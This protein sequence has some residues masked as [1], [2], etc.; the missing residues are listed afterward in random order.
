[1]L[2]IPRSS[3]AIENRQRKELKRDVELRQLQESIRDNG[4]LHPIVVAELGENQY[5]LVAGGRRLTA[6][7]WLFESQTS[8]YCDKELITPG[9]VPVILFHQAADILAREKAELAENDDRVDLT[10]QDKAQA[11]IRIHELEQTINPKQTLVDTAAELGRVL[12]RPAA[13]MAVAMTRAK[14]IVQHIADPAIRYARNENE[15]YGLAIRKEEAQ[16]RALIVKQSSSLPTNIK[17]IEGDSFVELPKLESS[18]IDLIIADPPYGISVGAEGFKNRTVHHHNYEDTPVAAR[19]LIQVILTEGFRITRPRSNLF[20]FCDIDLFPW[21]LS[22]AEAAGWTPFRTPI[23]WA[24]SDSEGLAPWGSQ[25]FRRTYELIFFA[26]KG[27]RGLI[28]SPVDILR[29]SRVG[30]AERDYAAAK[31]IS[32]LKELISCSTLPG[33]TIL[34]PCCGSGSALLAAKELKRVAIGI[35]K[36]NNAFN[37][38]M[39]KLADVI[40]GGPNYAQTTQSPEPE[41]GDL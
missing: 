29:H 20:I 3:I 34:D 1:M 11:L 14:K 39:A 9:F 5:K 32:L 25:G 41:I 22:T 18:T 27:Q 2:K 8:F 7:D 40:Q 35:E 12:N 19:N 21:L 36:D 28:T 24:K 33:E 30:R 13:S 37:L 38:T 10:W 26:T 4:L 16:I 17:V 23:I 31:P 6:I 15:A